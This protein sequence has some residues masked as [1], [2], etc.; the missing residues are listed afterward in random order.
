MKA[1]SD[2]TAEGTSNICSVKEEGNVNLCPVL[3]ILITL[4][5]SQQQ[6]KATFH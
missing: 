2:V 3:L 1:V 5:Y 6:I 4:G